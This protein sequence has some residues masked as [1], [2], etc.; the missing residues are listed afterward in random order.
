VKLK[1]L[2]FALL[3]AASVPGWAIEQEETFTDLVPGDDQL[4]PALLSELVR[5]N[6][7]R[8][9]NNVGLLW[10]KGFGG[11][12]SYQEAM[13]WWREAANRGFTVSMNN[14]GLLYASG[15]GVEQDMTQAFNW[16]H[17]AAF[18]GDAWA[19]NSVGDCYENGDGVEQD[20][21]MAMTWY[22]SAAKH[23]ERMAMFNIGGLF[24]RG[25]GVTQDY[26]EALSWYRKSAQA[27][28]A[29]AMRAIGRFYREGLGVEIDLIEAYAWHSV[30]DLRYG[31][32]EVAEAQVNRG[33][34]HQ[35]AARLSPEQIE[36]GRSRLDELEALTRPPKREPG[37]PPG[38]GE[39]RT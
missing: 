11:R 28:D 14:I 13:R 15:H 4:D 19:M 21:V 12:Q 8:A 27:G 2:A 3:L 37:G 34:L 1:V 26:G 6:N 29:S 36:R 31:A 10:A 30:A 32:Q 33:E 16:W 7:V 24:E 9:I 23:G 5:K 20:L 18:L 38:P 17:Q 25:K 39:A 35:L 22:Q